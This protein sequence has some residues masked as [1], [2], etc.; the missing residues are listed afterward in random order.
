MARRKKKKESEKKIDR[1]I[2]GMTCNQGQRRPS[3]FLFKTRLM[4][5]SLLS[6]TL[7]AHVSFICYV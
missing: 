3:Q 1:E 7:K 6:Y 5:A 4:H 2:E